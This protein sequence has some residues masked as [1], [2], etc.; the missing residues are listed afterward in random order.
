L[1]PE[2]V[3]VGDGDDRARLQNLAKERDL[4]ERVRFVGAQPQ[5]VL[6]DVYRMADLCVMPSTG[7]GF[8]IAF[9]EAMACGTP[10]LGFDRNIV[11]VKYTLIAID[12]KNS[13]SEEMVEVHPM[14]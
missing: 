3:V 14:R 12:R 9:L 10:A 5:G 6:A 2:Y 1:P 7:E 8:G 4:T 13:H 11:N